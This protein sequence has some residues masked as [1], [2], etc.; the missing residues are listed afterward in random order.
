ML[1]IMVLNSHMH[2]KYLSLYLE[3]HVALTAHQINFFLQQ[4]EII[5]KKKKTEKKCIVG[6]L[7]PTDT[8]I[9]GLLKLRFTE[10]FSR[11]SKK[12]IQAKEPGNL[13]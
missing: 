12:I 13:L 8:A 3:I 5:A 7:A 4:K 1:T 6:Y 10:H 9:S 2:S 11:G